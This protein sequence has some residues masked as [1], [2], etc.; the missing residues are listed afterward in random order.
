M[1]VVGLAIA[2]ILFYFCS[3]SFCIV[4]GPTRICR[5]IYMAF[6]GRTMTWDQG[7]INIFGC[8]IVGPYMG[9]FMQ[10]VAQEIIM[11]ADFV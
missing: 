11:P 1:D 2:V 5:A 6:L 7:F 9:R 10:R 8:L 4:M 3:V